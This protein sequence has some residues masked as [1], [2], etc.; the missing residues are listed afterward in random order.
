MSVLFVACEQW[1]GFPGLRSPH[2]P[3]L[4]GGASMLWCREAEDVRATLHVCE[5][6]TREG[7][8]VGAVPLG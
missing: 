5:W 8:S 1:R 4:H 2:A 7:P 6:L 3:Q